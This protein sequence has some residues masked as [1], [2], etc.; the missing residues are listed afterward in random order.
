MNFRHL[1][2][3][4]TIKSMNAQKMHKNELMNISVGDRQG[5]RAGISI[6]N[7]ETGWIGIHAC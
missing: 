3:S 5:V 6:V 2:D 1:L 7:D 4:D